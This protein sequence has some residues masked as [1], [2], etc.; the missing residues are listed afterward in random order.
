MVLPAP[1][2]MEQKMSQLLKVFAVLAENSGSVQNTYM[3]ANYNRLYL[4]RILHLGH[5]RPQAHTWYRYISV[6]NMHT[7]V[8]AHVHARAHTRVCAYTHTHTIL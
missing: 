4:E 5:L 8:H 7:H 6:G 2:N 1:I 3:V